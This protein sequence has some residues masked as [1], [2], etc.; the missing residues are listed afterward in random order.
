MVTNGYV[1]RGILKVGESEYVLG[2]GI[3]EKS[4]LS[5]QFRWEPKT[6]IKRKSVKKVI[7]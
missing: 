7:W 6:T 5:A 3:C 4:V 1:W 2:Q